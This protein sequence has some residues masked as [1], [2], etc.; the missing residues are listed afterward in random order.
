MPTR[1]SRSTQFDHAI[2]RLE[3]LSSEGTAYYIADHKW[4]C[5]D[6]AL[7]LAQ[8]LPAGGRILN[9]GGRPYLFEFIARELGLEVVSLDIDPSRD[10]AECAALGHEII[11]ADIETAE[12]RA[13]ARLDQY[14]IICLAEIFEHMRIDLLATFRDLST[15]MRPDARI[16]LTTPNFYSAPQL[17]KMLAA[18]R[19]GPSLVREWGKLDAIGHMGH[20]RE[21]ARCELI[22]FFAATG[23][24]V[25]TSF[26]RNSNEISLSAGGWKEFPFRVVARW[27]AGRFNRFGQELVFVLAPA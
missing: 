19:S 2:S 15:A 18:G 4:R 26:V 25:E 23:L 8:L 5:I 9:V 7:R 3:S 13:A 21:Y 6:D 20:V 17:F 1:A 10:P 16:Y 27:L 22:E 14:D 24:R 12:G 11:A